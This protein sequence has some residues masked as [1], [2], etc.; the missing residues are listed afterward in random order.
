[1]LPRLAAVVLPFAVA[2]LLLTWF[3]N[4]PGRWMG[5]FFFG[6]SGMLFIATW[7]SPPAHIAR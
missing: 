3:G 1:V 4:G 7:D 6:A 2:A 5:G